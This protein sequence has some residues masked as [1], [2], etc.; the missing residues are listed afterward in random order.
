[1]SIKWFIGHF[2][3]IESQR[4]DLKGRLQQR[5]DYDSVWSPESSNTKTTS[6]PPTDYEN[7]NVDQMAATN[8]E[9]TNVDQM[10]AT[11]YENTNVDQ[12]VATSYENTN[13]DQIVATNYENLPPQNSGTYESVRLPDSSHIYDALSKD[14]IYK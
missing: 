7:T 12:M 14:G 9:N 6:G 11:S 1:M 13:V 10:V 4:R 3:I 8:Y 2:I 5:T